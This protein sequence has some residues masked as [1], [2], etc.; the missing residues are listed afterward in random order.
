VF[1]TLEDETGS[2]NVVIW[3]DLARRQRPQV[4][5]ARLLGVIG[6][7]EQ[8]DNV[9]HLVAGR[10]E[11]HSQLLGELQTRSRDFH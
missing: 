7:W 3:N 2:V 9:S 11:D 10:L 4:V 5:G 6:I 1:L 8:R